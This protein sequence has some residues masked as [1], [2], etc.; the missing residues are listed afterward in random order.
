MGRNYEPKDGTG[1]EEGPSPL[2]NVRKWRAAPAADGAQLTV[3]VADDC[4][5]ISRVLY[6]TVQVASV[7]MPEDIRR[8]ELDFSVQAWRIVGVSPVLPPSVGQTLLVMAVT[9]N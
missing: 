8:V 1:W 2:P 3:T 5:V 9:L 7:P 6:G 4:F